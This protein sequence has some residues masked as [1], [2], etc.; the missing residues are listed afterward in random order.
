LIKMQL[1]YSDGE[2]TTTICKSGD[3]IDIPTNTWHKATNIGDR[4]AKVI[5]VWMGSHLSE[6]DIE[7]RD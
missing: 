3:S 2:S 7:R 1:E 5:E 4:V 6:S